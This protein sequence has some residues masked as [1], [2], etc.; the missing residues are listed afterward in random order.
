MMEINA[1]KQE[2]LDISTKIEDAQRTG[3]GQL[4]TLFARQAELQEILDLYNDIT[5][6]NQKLE[7]AKSL[8][9]SEDMEIVELAQEEV[10]NIEIQL[11]QKKQQLAIKL[12]PSDPNDSKN[13]IIEIRAATGG[14]EA[15]LFARDLFR[16]YTRYANTKNWAI[17][18]Y[19]VFESE[20]KGIKEVIFK[21]SGREVYKH[22]KYESG[23]HRVQR[24]P[25]TERSGRIHTSAASVV[26]IPAIDNINI[27]IEPKDIRI[28][29]FRSRG[30]GGQSVNTTDS[31]VRITH[32]PSGIIV[33]CQ[34]TKDQ[35]KNKA[36][37]LSVLKSKLYQLELGKRQASLTQIRRNSIKTGDRSDKIKTYNF[38]QDRLTDHRIHKSWYGL[39]KILDGEI[40]QI[41]E[42]TTILFHTENQNRTEF[43]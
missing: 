14:E 10:R 36:S 2:L 43:A 12:I 5:I 40:D 23:V 18:V 32:L 42:E 19:S 6:L 13:V 27:E 24:V 35:Q 31:A 17:Q 3:S 29:V 39:D 16:M 25:I 21:I 33:T 26:V 9:L 22:L 34:D 41:I 28:D 30:P 7:Q 11:S 37:A 38:P 20:I 15:S 1:I 4:A 8:I